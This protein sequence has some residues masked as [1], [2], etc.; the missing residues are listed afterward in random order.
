MRDLSPI[1]KAFI[2]VVVVSGAAVLGQ[3][4]MN[5]QPVQWAGF[6]A[7]LL[8]SLAASRL[9]VKLPG[10]TGAMSVNLPFILLAIAGLGR[11]EALAVAC[12]STFVQCIPR[13]RKNFNLSQMA[14]NV[15][16]MA[17]TV[18]ATRLLYDSAAIRSVVASHSLLLAIAAAGYLI[19]NSLPVAVIISLTEGRN[20]P[21]TW[22]GMFQLSFPYFVAG[23]GIAGVAIT[24]SA[25]IAWQLP[26]AVLPLMVGIFYSYRRYFS[27]PQSSLPAEASKRPAASVQAAS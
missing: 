27:N 3:A 20:L 11:A 1:S 7:L 15:S 16:S 21:R 10:L 5:R 2:A 9:R 14:F 19:L 8:A 18:G 6:L 22:I 12:L 25:N 26:L 17:L 13:A 23:A 24:L 4:L